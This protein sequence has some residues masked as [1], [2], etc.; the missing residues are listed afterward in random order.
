MS[1]STTA[2]YGKIF[3]SD[4]GEK[5]TFESFCR[6]LNGDSFNSVLKKKF[7]HSSQI[8][9]GEGLFGETER[10]FM[11]ATRPSNKRKHSS[12]IKF[13]E[14]MGSNPPKL[15]FSFGD[16]L[17]GSNTSMSDVNMFTFWSP[18]HKRKKVN[19]SNP[20]SKRHKHDKTMYTNVDDSLF[21][22]SKKF[23]RVC[24]QLDSLDKQVGEFEFNVRKLGQTIS[25]IKK[26]RRELIQTSA[27]AEKLLVTQ[28][29]AVDISELG[30]GKEQ[31][32]KL[33][34]S[35]VNRV[36]KLLEQID[37]LDTQIK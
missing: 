5:Y 12:Q 14:V 37:E 25:N 16:S 20:D 36:Q 28:I 32:R 3:G 18:P 8:K 2:S 35:L 22:K 34:K 19:T 11:E 6:E 30:S 21:G 1:N 15:E 29:D 27:S 33:R 13:G 10:K 4:S 17:F 26:V 31:A 24:T 9:F 7:A 23:E